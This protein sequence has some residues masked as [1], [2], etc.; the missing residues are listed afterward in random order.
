MAHSR[1]EDVSK[2]LEF[3]DR[4][5]FY[6]F[7]ASLKYHG[8]NKGDL[9]KH[10]LN[11]Y[12]TFKKLLI[13]LKFDEVLNDINLYHQ[14][15]RAALLHDICKLFYYKYDEYNNKFEYKKHDKN[16]GHGKLSV[17]ILDKLGIQLTELEKKMITFHMGYYNCYEFTD[18]GEYK[19]SELCSAQNNIYVKLLHF[20]DDISAQCLE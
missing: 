17:I 12:N 8:I 5:N 20:A 2:L 16:I 13:N 6:I 9:C 11:V 18:K 3:L 7:P 15:C 14:C 19:L 4:N 1:G 10:S